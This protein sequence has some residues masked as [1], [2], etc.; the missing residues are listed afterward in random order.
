MR[1]DL[2]LADTRH[3]LEFADT[4]DS[5]RAACERA[6]T[7]RRLVVRMANEHVACSRPNC[8]TRATRFY[9]DPLCLAHYEAARLEARVEDQRK[10]RKFM[11]ADTQARIERQE[12][13][14]MQSYLERKI[15]SQRRIRDAMRHRR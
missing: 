9:G 5:R 4:R 7:I 13:A 10:A 1:H 6:A 12:Q 2:E 11:D 14:Q 8:E 15:E 3:G